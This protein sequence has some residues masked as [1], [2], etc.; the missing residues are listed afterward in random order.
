MSV[1]PA[2]L[3]RAKTCIFP[4]EDAFDEATAN[5]SPEALEDLRRAADLMMR[6]LAGVLIELEQATDEP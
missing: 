1:D 6:A 5:P 4:L 2:I 3:H